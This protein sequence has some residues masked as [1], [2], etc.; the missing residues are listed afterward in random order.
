MGDGVRTSSYDR[1][2]TLDQDDILEKCVRRAYTKSSKASLLE[3]LVDK[4]LDDVW[5]NS[6]SEYGDRDIFTWVMEWGTKKEKAHID[7]RMCDGKNPLCIEEYQ[8]EHYLDELP[9]FK[10]K[11][12][13][14]DSYADMY[15]EVVG[16]D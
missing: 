6:D 5:G 12:E 10:A 11:L 2:T 15:N 7:Q 14:K 8:Y 1:N 3:E 13:K 9:Q 4:I 16:E